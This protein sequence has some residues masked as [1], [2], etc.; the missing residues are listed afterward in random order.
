MTRAGLPYE[1][2]TAR[3]L[4]LLRMWVFG[5]W[6]GD[7]LKDPVSDLATVPLAYYQPVGVMRWFPPSFWEAALSP[8]QLQVWWGA[9]AVLLLL[10]GAGVPFYRGVALAACVLLTFY[11]GVVFGFATVTHG[12]IAA[13]YIAWLLA[14]FPSADALSL[15]RSS[16]SSSS[17]HI[18][19]AAILT[20]TILLLSTYMLTGVRRVI[21][22]GT[23][24][25]LDGSILRFIARNS[26]SP[27]QLSQRMGL[28]VL[29]IPGMPI[30]MQ[31]GF[32][33]VTFFEITSLLCL[34]S[35]WFRRAWL[36]VMIPFHVLS[37][38]LLQLLFLHNIL[39]IAVLLV[40]LEGIAERI[41]LGRW[42]GARPQRQAA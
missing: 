12:P 23:E 10:S 17:D 30:V 2:A 11:Q 19:Q 7:L 26:V 21:E 24:I 18:Y 13:L 4:A 25:F 28:T 8:P 6:L 40:D 34:A 3:H 16:R 32:V 37:W 42:L 29:E 33:L 38:P 27:A 31:I 36:A 22:G 5:M 1:N 20:A 14:L 35:K 41:G 39:L 9:L 15:R